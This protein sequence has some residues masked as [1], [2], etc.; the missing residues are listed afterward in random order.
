MTDV[1][2]IPNPKDKVENA[3]H[4][5]VCSGKVKLAAAQIAIATDWQG[6]E[7]KLGIG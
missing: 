1:G 5:A 7:H 2:R 4:R 3:L 6:A